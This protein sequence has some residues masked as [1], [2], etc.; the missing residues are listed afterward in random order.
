MSASILERIEAHQ[1]RIIAGQAEIVDAIGGLVGRVDAHDERFDAMEG[2]L[3]RQERRVLVLLWVFPLACALSALA[4][5]W[6]ALR[7]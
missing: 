5:A 7:L 4:G 2:R 1:L 6:V 3:G